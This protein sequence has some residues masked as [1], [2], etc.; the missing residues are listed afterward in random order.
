MPTDFISVP[1]PNDRVTEVYELL[2]HP[3][4][5]SNGHWPLELVARAMHESPPGPRAA[6][7]LLA[8]R[9]DHGATTQELV[10]ELD[11]KR[12]GAA[13]AGMF[14]AFGRRCLRR[15][16]QTSRL[17]VRVWDP[18]LHEARYTLKPEYREAV[19]AALT[20]D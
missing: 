5:Q 13:L 19:L 8:E 9:G 3:T 4:P 20:G 1:V 2:A 17:Y 18:G 10:Q 15:Y 11:Y 14:G 12:G 7:E 6:F 16:G